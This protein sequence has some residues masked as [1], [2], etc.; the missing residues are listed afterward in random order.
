MRRRRSRFLHPHACTT[1]SV[2]AA[3]TLVVSPGH[4]TI[5]AGQKPPGALRHSIAPGDVTRPQATQWIEFE[6]R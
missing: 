6:V 5:L 3:I 2:A 4:P 1:V